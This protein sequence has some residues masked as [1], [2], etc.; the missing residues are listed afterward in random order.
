MTEVKILKIWAWAR[1]VVVSILLVLGDSNTPFT[2]KVEDSR[3]DM[4]SIFDDI[5]VVF[6]LEREV[7][8]TGEV[9]GCC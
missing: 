4:V 1:E 3:G 6:S 5:F 8:A 2:L 9:G 7:K